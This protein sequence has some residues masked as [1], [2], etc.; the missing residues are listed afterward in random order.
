ME[1]QKNNNNISNGGGG[2]GGIGFGG[3]TSGFGF[4]SKTISSTVSEY[5]SPKK[6]GGGMV[7]GNSHVPM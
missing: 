1:Q 2:G 4:F 6:S 7:S 5:T 3:I